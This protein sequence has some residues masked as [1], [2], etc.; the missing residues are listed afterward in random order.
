MAL[1]HR[2][3]ELVEEEGSS[4]KWQPELF[5]LHLENDRR[6]LDALL[7]SGRVVLGSDTL[8]LQLGELLTS[9]R[10]S[11]KPKAAALEALIQEHLGGAPAFEYGTWVHYPWSRRLVHVLP[12]PEYR[13]LRHARNRYKIMG[14]EQDLLARKTVG[15]VG[16][17][18]GQASAV[19]LAQEG[20]GRSFR[21]ADFDQLSLSNMNRLRASVASIGVPK[22][23]ISAREMFEIDPYLDIKVWPAGLTEDTV[24][25]FLTGDGKIDLLV[26]ECDDLFIKVLVRERARAHAIPTVMD[27][28]ERGMMDVERFDLDP[29]LPLLHG[30]LRDIRA[31]DLKG[32][33]T[34]DKVPYMVRILGKDLFSP[35][36]VPSLMEID[37]TISSWPQLASGVALGGAMVTDVARRILLDQFRGSGRFFVDLSDLIREGAQV[38]IAAPSELDAPVSP[39]ALEV[40]K[41]ELPVARRQPT[42]EDIRRLVEHATRAP[43]GGNVQPWR[44]VAR[45]AKIRCHLDS[46][47]SAVLLDFNRCATY[48]AMGA[49]IENIELAARSANLRSKVDLFP[50][51]SDDSLVCE[52]TLSVAPE[53]LEASPLTQYIGLRATNRKLGSRTPLLAEEL[54]ALCAAASAAEGRLAAITD[55]AALDEMGCILGAGD[56]VRFLSQRL[57]AE[58]MGEVRWTPEEVERTRDGVDLVTLESSRADLAGI[59]L[60]RPWSSILFLREIRGGGALEK[61]AKDSV[62]AASAIGFIT[63]DGTSRE[64]YVRGGRAMQ[65]V[66]LTASS[67]GLAMQPMA[68]LLYLWARVE[69]GGG[70]GLDAREVEVLGALRTRF[71]RL[72]DV[73]TNRADVM[74]F[75][76]ARAAPPSARALRRHV[77]DVLTFED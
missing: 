59:R 26:E 75:R 69:R 68:P 12:E 16:L 30:L 20:I 62:A 22:I 49:A 11:S 34:R 76:L 38:A 23:F 55:P 1:E 61:A 8:L 48:L 65:R 29:E 40:P 54:E 28:N 15:I 53:E 6:A 39:L 24:D 36:F 60:A 47:Q 27:T 7:D 66:W 77:D 74:L 41:L 2:V 52:L 17:S 42:K 71:K 44:F 19:T 46:S 25:E 3:R 35:R 9:R 72:F 73:T 45:G 31:S 51:S 4:S 5:N 58:M 33:S 10:A 70:E 63:I 43:S 67:L 57:H 13:E 21:L 32:L 14:N 50:D 37:E 18:V 64:S 56:R